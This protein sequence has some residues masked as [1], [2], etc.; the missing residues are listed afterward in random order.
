MRS[1]DEL[2]SVFMALQH[3]FIT[4]EFKENVFSLLERKVVNNKKKRGP[5]WMD[6]MAYTGACGDK[7]YL[8]GK[9]YFTVHFKA[10]TT[11]TSN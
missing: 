11:F 8:F 5:K 3:I 10:K 4:R 1:R 9:T 7:T 2:P 6:L